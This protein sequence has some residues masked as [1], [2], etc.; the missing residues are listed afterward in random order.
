MNHNM[1]INN[2]ERVFIAFFIL[3]FVIWFG[4]NFVRMAISYD[5]FETGTIIIRSD[6]R[7]DHGTVAYN[8]YL[9]TLASLYTNI[10]Y[11]VSSFAAVVLSVRLSKFMRVKG[12]LLMIAI[13]FFIN[14]PIELYYIYLDIQLSFAIFFDNKVVSAKSD[15]FHELFMLRFENNFVAGLKVISFLSAFTMILLAIWRPLSIEFIKI[16]E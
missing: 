1:Q 6:L 15:L 5:L 14:V 16:N 2:I 10:A 8:I 11:A 4:G 9:S 3:G 12:W 7:E 13:L